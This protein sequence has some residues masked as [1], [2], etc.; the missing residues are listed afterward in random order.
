M[1]LIILYDYSSRFSPG[2]LVCHIHAQQDAGGTHQEVGGDFLI[3]HP[4]SKYHGGDGIEIHPVGSLHRSQFRDAPVPGK[5]TDHGG[6][7]TQKEQVAEDLRTAEDFYRREPGDEKIIRQDS[8]HTIKEHLPGDERRTIMIAHRL[9]QQRI[10]G[11]AHASRKRQGIAHRRKMEHETAVQDH[12][13]HSH[14][15]Q[16]RTEQLHDVNTGRILIDHAHQQG[17]EERTGTYYQRSIGG[18]GEVHRLV[19]AVEIERAARDTQQCHL[20]LIPPR[21][22]KETAVVEAEHQHLGDGKAQ[23]E[24]LGWRKPIQHQHLGSYK[25]GTPYRHCEEGDEVI[26][27]IAI[28]CHMSYT[29]SLNCF[30]TILS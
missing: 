12:D 11:P 13:N 17:G 1:I 25:G 6:Q 29:F 24:D 2:F 28:S 15:S 20:S 22:G 26:E 30:C 5:E 7:T 10:N 3:E 18:C 21:I 4:R 16:Q 14:K 19:L 27:Y 23:R 9:H 8:Q